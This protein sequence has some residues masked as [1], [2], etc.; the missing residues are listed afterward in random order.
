MCFKFFKELQLHLILIFFNLKASFHLF[1]FFQ[2]PIS[3]FLGGVFH[4]SGVAGGM[5]AIDQP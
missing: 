5:Q 4:N 1:C 3:F 2:G